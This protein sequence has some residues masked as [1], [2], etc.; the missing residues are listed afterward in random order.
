MASFN[1]E[2]VAPEKLI[3]AGEVDGVVVPATEGE[4]TVLANHAPGMATLK[5]GVL[6]ILDG[7]S[8]QRRIFVRGG[9]ADIGATGLTILAEHAIALE[10]LKPEALAQD[11]RNAEDDARDAR[12]ED[13]KLKAAERLDHLRQLQAALF[14]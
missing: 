3:F 1:F 11:I 2:L 8:G 10:D 14:N 5:A 13:A 7:R 12:S 4:M 9:F 6:T